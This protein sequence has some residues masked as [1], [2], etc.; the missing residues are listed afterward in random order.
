MKRSGAGTLRREQ[1]G[2]RILLQAWVQRRRDHGGVLFLDLRDRSGVAQVVAKPDVSPDALAVLDPVRSEWVVEVEGVRVIDLARVLAGPFA[3]R[4]LAALGA[5]VLKVESPDDP[6][7]TRSIGPEIFPGVSAYFLSTNDSKRSIALDLKSPRGRAVLLDLVR[8]SDVL[9]ENFRP[10]VM[11]RL[12]LSPDALRSHN[13]GLVTASV[14]SVALS[15]RASTDQLFTPWLD[16]LVVQRCVRLELW[17]TL[18]TATSRPLVQLPIRSAVEPS[19]IVLYDALSVL[20]VDV[21]SKNTPDAK[22]SGLV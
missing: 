12:G 22:D 20:P 9:V 2:E 17:I 18:P 10:G 1:V 7:T 13:A 14:T 3:A 8:V 21:E 5:D 11:E 16:Q 15:E 4:C 19:S 6:D